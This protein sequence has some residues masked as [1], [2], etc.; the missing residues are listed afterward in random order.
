MGTHCN[1]HHR[2]ASY[3]HRRFDGLGASFSRR[4]ASPGYTRD[5]NF[6]I[7]SSKYMTRSGSKA[8]VAAAA[9]SQSP[10]R[11]REVE[12]EKQTDKQTGRQ[13]H[14][15]RDAQTETHRHTHT[16]IHTH[17]HT[18]TQA[19]THTHTHTHTHKHRSP[20]WQT[21]RLLSVQGSFS[22][23]SKMWW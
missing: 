2:A 19:H 6:A 22:R 14:T 20:A 11:G 16:I 17:T 9:V 12:R 8:T 21:A 1:Y 3:L 10:E 15:G 5:W 7:T 23:L 18:R 4:V 13:R